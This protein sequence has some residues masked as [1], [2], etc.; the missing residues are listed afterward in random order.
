MLVIYKPNG[1]Y[2][3]KTGDSQKNK[4]EE[5][6]I[7]PKKPSKSWENRAREDSHEIFKKQKDKEERDENTDY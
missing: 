7:S 6:S 4:K 1:N 2:K 3:S 5:F